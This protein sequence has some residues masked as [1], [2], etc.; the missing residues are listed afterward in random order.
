MEGLGETVKR[1]A[2]LSVACFPL[3]FMCGCAFFESLFG[4]NPD[5]TVQ[6][7]GGP[8][9]AVSTLVNYWIPGATAV[10]GGITTLIAAVK[11]RNWKKAFT[12]TAEVVEAGAAAGKAVADIKP[13]LMAAH[14]VAGV[15]KIVE[16]ALDESV[17]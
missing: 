12:T 11:A 16:K 14:A 9:G 2:F 17:R 5:G 13:E 4:V 1:L 3:F 8:M 7:G 6:P 10:A 15:G